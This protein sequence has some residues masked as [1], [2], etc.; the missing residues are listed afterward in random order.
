MINEEYKARETSVPSANKY[1]VF[2]LE[3]DKKMIRIA[4]IVAA[5]CYILPTSDV[6]NKLPKSL[7]SH[8]HSITGFILR[9][10]NTIMESILAIPMLWVSVLLAAAA[11]MLLLA[12]L[13]EKVSASDNKNRIA[14]YVLCAVQVLLAVSA[15]ATSLTGDGSSIGSDGDMELFASV[16]ALLLMVPALMGLV[17]LE[18][19]IGIRFNKYDEKRFKNLGVCFIT[20]PIVGFILFFFSLPLTTIRWVRKL[21]TSLKLPS[22]VFGFTSYMPL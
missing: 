21:W 5:I 22:I 17:V 2:G 12:A 9:T 13:A 6:W 3:V 15:L 10:L 1:S 4:A 16:F 7:T 14:L 18:I 20:Y 11:T 19:Y 8:S